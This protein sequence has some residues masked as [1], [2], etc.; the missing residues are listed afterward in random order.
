MG[1]YPPGE[2]TE[3]TT[4]GNVARRTILAL[5]F[6]ALLAMSSHVVL[7][8]RVPHSDFQDV[9]RLQFDTDKRLTVA[10]QEMKA[11]QT[12]L[13]RLE[14]QE[15][16]DRATNI[17]RLTRLET[18]SNENQL[19]IR[20]IVIGVGVLVLAEILKIVGISLVGKRKKQVS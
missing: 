18:I 3:L 20:G 17:E 1:F 8:Q 15:S 16:T 5:M 13:D 4:A 14:V 6:F 12:R 10:E 2:V 11:L 7:S 9:Q 19:M